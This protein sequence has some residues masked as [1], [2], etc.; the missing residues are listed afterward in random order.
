LDRPSTKALAKRLARALGL[1]PL[2]RS[3]TPL[4]A[5]AS[6]LPP[7]RDDVSLETLDNDEFGARHWRKKLFEHPRSP[8]FFV[9]MS[10]LAKAHAVASCVESFSATRWL[11]KV[12]PQKK[13][14]GRP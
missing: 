13:G 3:T 2:R 5:L 9:E 1:T 6:R 8:L 14:D 12:E 11:P 10:Y 7:A 4:S